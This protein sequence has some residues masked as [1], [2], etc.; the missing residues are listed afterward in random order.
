MSLAY[1]FLDPHTQGAKLAAYIVG[2]A[3]AEVVLFVVVR[4]VMM[5]R[6]MLIQ[7]HNAPTRGVGYAH[8]SS[9]AAEEAEEAETK[10]PRK[11]E[12]ELDDW[13]EVSRPGVAV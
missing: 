2:I 12:E 6:S 3:A 5:L 4:Y 11:G 10:G 1:S 9:D 7:R 13:Q 8:S